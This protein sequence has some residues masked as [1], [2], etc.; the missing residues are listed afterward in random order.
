MEEQKVSVDL[1]GQ[2]LTITTGKMAK[3][4]AGSAVVQ[5]G[6]TVVLVA[7]SAA[8]TATIRD[9]IPLTVDYRERT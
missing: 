3:L 6:D 8:K 7:S 4:A 2:T 5:L 1:G 9:F